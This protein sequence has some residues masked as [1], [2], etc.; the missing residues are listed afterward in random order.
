MND[1]AKAYMGF[2][3]A[4]LALLVVIMFYMGGS[5]S[6]IDHMM[7]ALTAIITAAVTY[8]VAKNMR[9]VNAGMPV[10]DELSRKHANKVGAWSYYTTIWVCVALVW[11]NTLISDKL[12]LTPLTAVES[13]GTV[14]LVSGLAWVL[15]YFTLKKPME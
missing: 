12:G 3:V 13:L 6:Q 5:G 10:E 9:E 2:A 15:L 4:G 11:Y 14:V 8:I 1:K 7:I